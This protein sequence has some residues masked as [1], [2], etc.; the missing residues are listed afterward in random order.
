M[1]TRDRIIPEIV[2]WA[3]LL[4]FVIL[5]FVVTILN[6]GV[7]GLDGSAGVVDHGDLWRQMDPTSHL[8]YWL[9][10]V[11]CHQQEARTVIICGSQ[12]PF[13]IRETMLL[14]GALIGLG[15]EVASKREPS[16]KVLCISLILSSITFI[17]WGV[18]AVTSIDV[19]AITATTAI[20]SGIGIGVCAHE[21]V[22]R[23]MAFMQSRFIQSSEF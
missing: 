5:M 18:K 7:I 11:G 23:T 12:M 8:I 6:D 17:E 22:Q 2:S 21:I 9:G 19:L 16:N 4:V 1:L 3:V 13:C 14:I 20:I 10:D 15:L